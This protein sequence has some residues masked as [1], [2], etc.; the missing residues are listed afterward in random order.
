[1]KKII[2]LTA[3]VL[4]A[5]LLPLS[6][7][8][9]SSGRK[10][11]MHFT[12]DIIM[13]IPVKSTAAKRDKKC[14][15]GRTLNNAGY[16]YLFEAV[17]GELSTGD[18]VSGNMEFPVAPPFTSKP[19]LFN[20]RPEVIPAM[21]EAGFTLMHLGNNHILD[22]GEK[23]VVETIN[24]LKAAGLDYTGADLTESGA[25]AGRLIEK[26]GIRIAVNGYTAVMNYP[27]PKKNKVFFLNNFSDKVSVK[28]DIAAMRAR[29]DY[30]VLVAHF[31]VEYSPLPSKADRALVKEYAEA[32]ADIIIG[33]HPHI[34]QP[35]EKIKTA[36]GRT[37]WVF[38]SLGNFISN[39][40]STP[41]SGLKGIK[42]HTRDS[43][44]VRIDAYKE[45]FRGDLRLALSLLPVITINQHDPSGLRR[46]QTV[47][48]K[49]E[50]ASLEARAAASE[51]KAIKAGIAVAVSDIKK[52]REALKAQVFRLMKIED[53]IFEE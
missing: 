1:M 6:F 37:A 24:R 39:Q 46:L 7:C 5:F 43:F 29:A 12:G 20:C 49:D 47:I 21:K 32:G 51:D 16:D 28:K 2:R 52:R 48:M 13:H 26:N 40:S 35:V 9:T 14:A 4:I 38:Y 34:V 31:G 42:L 33:H 44:I 45:G 30:V 41:N 10:M 18:I 53:L 17:R 25:G 36:D 11:R 15:E 3:P 19:F 27:M 8:G 23:G 22:Q 50:I